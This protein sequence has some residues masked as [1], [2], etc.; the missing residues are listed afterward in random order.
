[1][2]GAS[3]PT[4]GNTGA[5]PFG[6]QQQGGTFGQAQPTNSGFGSAS[7]NNAQSGF[8]GF[9]STQPQ[10]TTSPFG[11]SQQPQSNASPF[12]QATSSVSNPPALFGGNAAAQTA[13]G[14]TALKPFSAY[15]EKDA[16][17]GMNNVYESVSCMPEYKNYSFEELRF[18]DYQANNKFGQGG[19]GVSG[20]V[21]SSF[22]GQPNASP[23]GTNNQSAFGIGNTNATS[24][25]GLFGQSNTTNTTNPPFGQS[26]TNNAFGQATNSPFG[27][28]GTSTFGQA[29]TANSPFGQTN[30]AASSPF[31]INKPGTTSGGLFGQTNSNTIN[32]A[33]GQTAAGTGGGGLF[34]QTNTANNA[35]PF[36]QTSTFSQTNNTSAGGLFGQNNAQQQSGGLFGSTNNQQQPGG[37]F[38]QSNTQQQG[39]GLFGAT[40]TTNAFNQNNSSGGLFNK[41][42]TSSGLFGQS[43]SMFG[44]NTNTNTNGNPF[45]QNSTSAGGLFGQQTNQ[46][47]GTGLFGQQNNQQ[48]GGL[49]RPN[50]PQPGNGLFGQNNQPQGGTGLFGQDN[51]N[52]A[53]RQNSGNVTGGLF[54]NKPATGG[55]FGQ[56]NVGNTFGQSNSATSNTGGLFGQNNNQQQQQGGGLFGQNNTQTQSDGLFG[57]NNTQQQ[58]GGLFGQNN[59]TQQQA[60][61]LFGQNNQQ[62]GGLFGSKPAG[63]NT[64]GLFGNNKPSST[65]GMFGNN[66]NQ[67]GVQSTSG[68]LFGANNNN[69]ASNQLSGTSGGLFGNKPAGNTGGGL[70]GRNNGT[71]TGTLGSGLFGNNTNTGSTTNTGTGG[72]LFGAK[73]SDQANTS[74]TGGLF[75]AKTNV[76]SNTGTTSGN[77]FGNKPIGSTGTGLFDSKPAGSGIGG[78]FGNNSSTTASNGLQQSTIGGQ[79][80]VTPQ[81]DNPY[82]TNDLF[83]RVIVP[84]SLLQPS[85]PCATKINADYKKKAS[86]TSAYRLAP[87]PL[88]TST[89][90]T[91]GHLGLS[92]S[93]NSNRKTSSLI[94]PQ[95][96]TRELVQVSS[97]SSVFTNET[98]ELILSSSNK[99]FNPNKK[100]FKN[101]ILNR[102]KMENTAGDENVDDEPRRITFISNGSGEQEP[103]S[104]KESKYLDFIQDTPVDSKDIMK[105]NGGLF[106]T[107][108]LAST[109]I[110]ANSEE[111]AEVIKPPRFV[112]DDVSF[113][114]DGYYISPSLET[115]SSLTLLQLRKVSGLTIGHKLYGKI[116]F[117]KPVDLSNISLPSLCGNLV[118]FSEKMSEISYVGNDIP[119]PGDQ[120]NVRARIILY[121]T[122][123]TDKATRQP[124]KDPKHPI[125]KRHIEKLK[126]IE[127]TKFESYDVKTGTYTFVVE[128]PVA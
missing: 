70:F 57:S 5:S 28:T 118:R 24:T 49:F 127:H 33:F 58:G 17:T 100:S 30:N 112:G 52:N 122:F 14:G 27:Q 45:G 43:G 1:M 111:K 15:T 64:G 60:G 63:T 107:P 102:K 19:A 20:N 37:L 10:S 78:L 106:S 77:L 48:Q 6:Q 79:G 114:D 46:Q 76:T 71:Q 51:S 119:A 35:S 85:K 21:G 69:N 121:N 31:G 117:L 53:F 54:G 29:N 82:G 113:N 41:P 73:P 88:F 68:E 94:S 91:A 92:G 116:E 99:L 110:K 126:K 72:G 34:G 97:G 104:T 32:N 47:Q 62:T 98:D 65:G 3:R 96:S 2:F 101:L 123:P 56:T 61:G 36:G 124:I 103:T 120:L 108:N 83:S 95:S 59:N 55:L 115:L 25:G 16:T 109:P 81:G 90:K 11:M 8:G 26:S 50:N 42:T 84:S 89:A 44:Q 7:A 86:L 9:G 22:G 18:Q 4:F 74:T 105:S 75:G 38:G 80:G 93:Q 67:Q 87:K 13:V 128:T 40:N 12:G 125:L 23:F 66:N 39:G